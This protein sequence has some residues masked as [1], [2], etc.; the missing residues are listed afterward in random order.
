MPDAADSKRPLWKR[1]WSV[2]STLDT[3]SDIIKWLSALGG[4]SMGVLATNATARFGQF[5]I[6]WFASIVAA[7]CIGAI[8]GLSIVHVAIW[9]APRLVKLFRRTFLSMPRIRVT[10][11]GGQEAVLE[12]DNVG[13]TSAALTA[14]GRI[15]SVSDGWDHKRQDIFPMLWIPHW[16]RAYVAAPDGA[17]STPN[18]PPLKL[19]IAAHE[20]INGPQGPATIFAVFGGP[21]KVDAINIDPKHGSPL[22]RIEVKVVSEPPMKEPFI[23]TYDVVIEPNYQRV[24]TLSESKP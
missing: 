6:E 20:R 5:T 14:W 15:V 7:F 23:Q 2:I 9:V 24:V 21:G 4:G 10:P 13:K 16:Q 1:A 17:V 22:L 3:L 18:R 8:I 19:A 11:R 12:I